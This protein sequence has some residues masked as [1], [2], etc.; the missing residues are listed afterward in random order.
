MESSH[1]VSNCKDVYV[2]SKN[3][4]EVYYVLVELKSKKLKERIIGKKSDNITPKEAY[5]KYL[6]KLY[7]TKRHKTK[8]SGVFWRNS[9]TNGKKDKT[10]YI[11]YNN[12]LGKAVESSVGKDSQGIGVNYSY[13]KYLESVNNIKL[14]E[15][16]PIKRKRRNIFTLADAFTPYIAHA[17]TEKKSWA[18]DEELYT[19][20]LQEF[21]QQELISLTKNDFNKLKVKM[22]ETYAPRTVQYVLAVA[23][24]IINYAI[25]EDLVKNY[26]NPISNGKVKVKKID[27][28]KIGFF[29]HE[30][31]NLLLEKLEEYKGYTSHIYEL[32]V[33][34]LHTGGRF[35]EV[36]SLTWDNIDFKEKTI[37][38]KSTKDGNERHISMTKLVE[39]ILKSLP[40][41]KNELVLSTIKGTQIGQ[42]PKKWQQVVDTIIPDN[43]TTVDRTDDDGEF[44]ELLSKERDLL[45]QQNKTRLTT[46]SLRHTHASWMAISG[47]FNLMEIRDELGHKSIKMTERYAHLLPKERHRKTNEL[48][49][50]I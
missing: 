31:A 25:N 50:N 19:N 14:G 37:Y 40:N 16:P 9:T 48:F 10:Y 44:R 24:Q 38:F 11:V 34:L 2:K 4:D 41:K 28:A 13:Q 12:E 33:F 22:L 26:V 45:K 23:R 7:L 8:Y 49:D 43:K 6:N 5:Q 47:N 21:H 15:Q 18:K 39:E 42:M 30:Q 3:N 27:N 29:T 1:Q 32:T 46:H 35:S 36:A 20:H 17:K